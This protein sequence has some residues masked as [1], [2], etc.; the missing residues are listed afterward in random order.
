LKT[1]CRAE[2]SRGRIKVEC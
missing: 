1:A 2:N